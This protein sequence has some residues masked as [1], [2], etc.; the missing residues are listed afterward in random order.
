VEKMDRKIGK[1]RK[2]Q[3]RGKERTKP[4]GR[5]NYCEGG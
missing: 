4:K 3:T 1:Y 5:P 2:A